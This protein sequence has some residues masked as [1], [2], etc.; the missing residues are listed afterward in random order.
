M[1]VFTDLDDRV[2]EVPFDL[3]EYD[4]RL[5]ACRE[6]AQR[7]ALLHVTGRERPFE[8]TVDNAPFEIP[9]SADFGYCTGH[10]R[11]AEDCS[12]FC[13]LLISTPVALTPSFGWVALA[14]APACET[15][16]TGSVTPF[17]TGGLMNSN[18]AHKI[19]LRLD[20]DG[21]AERIA[22]GRS[23]EIPLAAM[24]RGI[25]GRPCGILR[26]GRRLLER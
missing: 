6:L 5:P 22:Y 10:T 26:C 14:F 15:S 12:T 18:P 20:P 19:R 9:T 25:R 11:R 8:T 17:D 7:I 1:P 16:H 24:A 13:V 23:S 21:D 4:R 2:K 3:A